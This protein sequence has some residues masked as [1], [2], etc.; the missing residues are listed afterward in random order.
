MTAPQ[1]SVETVE[2]PAHFILRLKSLKK[3]LPNDDLAASS[4]INVAHNATDVNTRVCGGGD[5]E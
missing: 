3:A 1:L 4:N 2:D 5:A